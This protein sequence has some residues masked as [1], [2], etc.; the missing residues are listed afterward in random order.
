LADDPRPS[1]LAGA[2]M[3]GIVDVA[4]A[5]FVVIHIVIGIYEIHY[6]ESRLYRTLSTGWRNHTMLAFRIQGTSPS[7]ILSAVKA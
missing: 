7:H 2:L 5:G 4:R 6:L 3:F 1:D